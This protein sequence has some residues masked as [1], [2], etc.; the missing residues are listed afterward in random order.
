MNS[1]DHAATDPLETCPP[2]AVIL[3]DLHCVGCGYNLRT[4]QFAGRCPECGLAVERS[5]LVLPRPLDTGKAIMLSAFA[6]VVGF[7]G[8][9]VLPF[10]MVALAMLLLAAHRLRYRCKLSHM[11][12]LGSKV[13]WFWNTIFISA[14]VLVLSV[15]IEWARGEYRLLQSTGGSSMFVSK[16]QTSGRQITVLDFSEVSGS[17]EVMTDAQGRREIALLDESGNVVSAS[18]LAVGESAQVKDAAGNQRSQRREILREPDRTHQLR[19]FGSRLNAGDAQANSCTRVRQ[20]RAAN[21]AHFQWHCQLALKITGFG[22]RPARQRAI[23][24]VAACKRMRCRF[25]GAPV[26]AGRNGDGVHAVHDA[27]VMRGRSVRID[28][29]QVVGRDNAVAYDLRR[30]SLNPQ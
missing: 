27:L 29:G 11:S 15:T 18:T 23:A 3:R 20:Q 14:L 13:R 30:I 9:Y 17:L 22:H 8:L 26:I 25:D 7:V 21:D 19:Q 12:E 6:L 4:M 2:Q 16:K 5:L 10:M 24:S 28:H 1:I